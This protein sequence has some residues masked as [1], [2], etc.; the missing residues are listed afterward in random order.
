VSKHPGV[1]KEGYFRIKLFGKTTEIKTIIFPALLFVILLGIGINGMTSGTSSFIRVMYSTVIIASVSLSIA[2]YGFL[3]SFQR[4]NIR[5]K[6]ISVESEFG[7]AMFHLGNQLSSGVPIENAIDKNQEKIRDLSISG[8]FGRIV[9]NIKRMGMTFEQAI[10]EK[11]YGAIWFYPSSLIIS[12]MKVVV[13]AVQKGVHN[14][15]QSMLSI[16]RYLKDVHSIEEQL[17]DILGESTTSMKFLG[18]V[19]APMVAGVTVTMAMVMLDI[20][21]ALGEKLAGLTQQGVGTSLPMFLTIGMEKSAVTAEIFQLVVG[22][23]M[24][25]VAGL[26]S[27]FVSKIETGEDKINLYR[28]LSINMFVS[29]LVYIA[30]IFMVYSVFGTQIQNVIL[31]GF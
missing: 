19:L 26:L 28:A 11:N 4:T 17:R 24:I 5:K 30:S 10:F 18:S 2:L 3:S 13:E 16:S 22:I 27:V 6:V 31:G 15:A 14:A 25:E 23:Y 8:F 9:Q 20:I 29:L 1:P 12:V 7:E 21:T